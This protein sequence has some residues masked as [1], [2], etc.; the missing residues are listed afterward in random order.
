MIRGPQK[1]DMEPV[2]YWGT[3]LLGTTARNL[4]A[5][6]LCNPVISIIIIIIIIIIIGNVILNIRNIIK[7]A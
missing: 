7:Q 3:K 2:S 5:R 6:V 4:V 1:D